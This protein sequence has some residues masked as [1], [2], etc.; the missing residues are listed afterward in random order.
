MLL[1]LSRGFLAPQRNWISIFQ[2]KNF[3][4]MRIQP[5]IRK[6]VGNFKLSRRGNV[7]APAIHLWSC[8]LWLAG[9][10][11]FYWQWIY[12]SWSL[13][14]FSGK[15]GNLR[16]FYV[17][18]W[19][20]TPVSPQWSVLKEVSL[21]YGEVIY[22]CHELFVSIEFQYWPMFL[23]FILYVISWKF[24]WKSPVDVTFL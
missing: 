13:L 12:S 10:S 8:L 16:K 19:N 9:F 23:V 20:C 24:C 4:N 1:R 17:N 2:V 3:W 7:L 11:A 6:C 21:E 5:K 15:Q 22:S 18:C 14:K